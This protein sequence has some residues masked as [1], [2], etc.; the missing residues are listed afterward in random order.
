MKL[1]VYR[2]GRVIAYCDVDADNFEWAKEFR[3]LIQT[4]SVGG[5]VQVCRYTRVDGK[6]RN[7]FL[8][9]EIM[10]ETNPA[11]NVYPLNGNPYDLR[12]ENLG[13]AGH[14]RSTQHQQV[15]RTVAGSPIGETRVGSI[16]P[17]VRMAMMLEERMFR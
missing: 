17:I 4:R 11:K 3:W 10:Q 8:A 2:Y 9:R 7:I 6:T 16:G 14:K 5:Q 12:R 15:T 1:P 13:V